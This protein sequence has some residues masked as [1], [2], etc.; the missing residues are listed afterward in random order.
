LKHH[1][2]TKTKVTKV[3][4]ELSKNHWSTR[5]KTYLLRYHGDTDRVTK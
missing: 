3:R 4:G 5:L 1:A 2:I